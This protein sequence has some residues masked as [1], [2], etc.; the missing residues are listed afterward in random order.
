MSSCAAAS[1][2]SIVAGAP[3]ASGAAGAEVSG[4]PCW[5]DAFSWAPFDGSSSQG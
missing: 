4:P 3:A 1:T 5:L 2:A